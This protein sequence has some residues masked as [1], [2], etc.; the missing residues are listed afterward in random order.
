[1]L[2]NWN[3]VIRHCRRGAPHVNLRSTTARPLRPRLA[4]GQLVGFIAF[5]NADDYGKYVAR[6]RA[7]PRYLEQITALLKR[8]VAERWVQPKGPLASIPTQIDGQI[9]KDLTGSPIFEPFRQI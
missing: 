5:R 8:G 2:R 4:L 6:L 7:Y 3:L 9:V 1:M